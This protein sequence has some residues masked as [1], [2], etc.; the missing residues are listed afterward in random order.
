MQ[1]NKIKAG[2]VSVTVFLTALIWV[3]AD[4]AQDERLELPNFV[5]ITMAKSSDPNLWVALEG[6]NSM[7]RASQTIERVVLKGP[8]SRVSEI[9]RRK[10][11]EKLDLNLFLVPEQMGLT[12][13]TTTGTLD[14]LSFLKETDEIRQLGLTV[15]TCEPRMITFQVSRLRIE[16]MKVECIDEMGNQLIAE[17]IEPPLV[18][19]RIPPE[20]ATFARVRLTAEEQRQAREAA[21]EKTPYIELSDGQRRDGLQPVK[22]KLPPAANVL[23]QYAVSGTIALCMSTNMQ[24]KYKVELREDPMIDLVLVQATAAAHQGYDKMP[25]HMLLY[26]EDSDKSS[27]E[28]TSREVIF[29][30]PPEY[31]E[32]GEIKLDQPVP[33]VQ[34]RL[35]PIPDQAPSPGG[36]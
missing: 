25:F 28:Y 1:H 33:K 26:I 32:R 36:M 2:K 19:V 27:Q 29:S 7:L 34:F 16:A 22:V 24:S 6:D 17:A 10:N 23:R 20:G 13:T 4:L 9:V 35:V 12:A 21:V 30:F 18:K 14:M 5:T 31:V 3:W 11:R 8:A 15:E